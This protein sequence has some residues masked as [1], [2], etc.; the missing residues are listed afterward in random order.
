MKGKMRVL[1]HW[2]SMGPYHFARM[3]ELASCPG[4]E[5]TV[6]ETTNTDDHGW[7]RGGA[8]GAFD[9]ITLSGELLS[10]A[11]LR[12]TAP[13]YAALM[14][15]VSPDVVVAGGYF[16]RHS[17][18]ALFSY[19]RRRPATLKLL[20]HSSAAHDHARQWW[21]ERLKSWVVRR[22]DGALVAGT[23]HG[24]YIRHLGMAGERLCVSG[25]CIDNE[26]FARGAEHARSTTGIRAAM[27]LPERYF[28]YVGRFVAKKNLPALLRA[29]ELYR[30]RRRAGAWSLVL[31]GDGPEAGALRQIARER[32][33]PVIFAGNRQVH[34]LPAFYGLA[35]CLVL[36]SLSEPWGLVVNESLASGTPVLISDRCGC[37]EDLVVEGRNGFCFAPDDVE[38]LAGLMEQM[39]AGRL[40]LQAMGMR[41][42]ELV[43]AFSPRKFAERSAAHMLKLREQRTACTGAAERVAVS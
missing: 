13:A 38:T 30:S 33:L 10:P 24:R 5:L 31:A 8:G 39:S 29:F 42:R 25:E 6:A 12:S 16:D 22:F 41:G 34:E 32:D 2:F 17:C 4:I 15:R 27:G 36:P 26:Y 1:W 20:W 3:S 7:Q 28:L 18:G 40:D 21:R 9:L 11:L 43:A 19:A 14:E 37:A 35:G 23:P